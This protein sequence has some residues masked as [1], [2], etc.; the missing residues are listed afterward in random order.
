MPNSSCL[1]PFDTHRVVTVPAVADHF[2][3]VLIGAAVR[4]LRP[5]E[6]PISQ[7]Q[8]TSLAPWNSH[9]RA[10]SRLPQQIGPP[11]AVCQL[12][13]GSF[14]RSQATSQVFVPTPPRPPLLALPVI[15]ELQ[16]RSSI[17]LIAAVRSLAVESIVTV[18]PA[19]CLSSGRRVA[20]SETTRGPDPPNPDH[21]IKTPIDTQHKGMR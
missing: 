20:A 16:T 5:V 4:S 21:R 2:I 17:L 12:S 7:P 3:G 9:H 10:V 15:T 8:R 18:G 14:S 6:A 19:D 13:I 1:I 11:F